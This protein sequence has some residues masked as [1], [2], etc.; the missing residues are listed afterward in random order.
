VYEFNVDP[1]SEQDVPVVII[2]SRGEA[3]HQRYH[4]S[5]VHCSLSSEVSSQLEALY[6]HGKLL[7]IKQRKKRELKVAGSCRPNGAISAV[8][9]TGSVIQS[10]GMGAMKPASS[11]SFLYDSIYDDDVVVGRYVPLGALEGDDD[12]GTTAPLSSSSS[13]SS[14]SSGHQP[15][16]SIAD[17]LGDGKG[18]ELQQAMVQQSRED[19]MKPVQVS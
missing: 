11:S 6:K 18:Q 19:L 10:G 13:S 9:A 17:M 4:D 2:K 1:L 14:A 3:R 15:I 8:D 7:T 12:G 5:Y 16:S